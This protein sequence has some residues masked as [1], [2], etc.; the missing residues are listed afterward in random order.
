VSVRRERERERAERGK[1]RGAL[2]PRVRAKQPE[3][4]F[5]DDA[6]SLL[7]S[8][9]SRPLLPPPVFDSPSY[10]LSSSAPCSLQRETQIA[11]ELSFV[12]YKALSDYVTRIPVID[13]R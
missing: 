8:Q 4:G 1:R 3:L 12:G 6:K 9:L 7:P 11:L 2:L 13:P 10:P 5:E